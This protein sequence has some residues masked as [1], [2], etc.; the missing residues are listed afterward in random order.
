MKRQYLVNA[1]RSQPTST[2]AWPSV[3]PVL[4]QARRAQG[5]QEKW[6]SETERQ[7]EQRQ[8]ERETERERE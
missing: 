3:Q 6:H 4:A 8:P 1:G 7:A 5:G 2:T